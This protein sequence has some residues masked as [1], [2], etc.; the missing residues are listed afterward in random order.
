MR[1]VAC[2]VV[3]LVLAIPPLFGADRAMLLVEVRK[4]VRGVK[5]ASENLPPGVI[6]GH[7]TDHG[8]EAE[9]RAGPALGGNELYLFSDGSYLSTEWGCLLSET[10]ADRGLWSYRAGYVDLA[11]DHSVSTRE[12]L[13]ER[14]FAVLEY[15]VG[16]E[17]GYRLMGIEKDLDYFRANASAGDDFML[18]LCSKVQVESLDP[19]KGAALKTKLLRTAWNPDFFR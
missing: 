4:F 11:S 10:I 6:A 8:P 3:V 16:A 9:Q 5:L 19:Q 15:R 18:L 12:T 14:R 7:Y 1:R 2:C 13:P 17:Q